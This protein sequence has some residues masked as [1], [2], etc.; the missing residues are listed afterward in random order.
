[1]FRFTIRDVLWLTVVVRFAL[2][3]GHAFAV[4]IPIE[5]RGEWRAVACEALGEKDEDCEKIA[6]L[7]S[8]KGIRVTEG[9]ESWMLVITSLDTSAS[10][11]RIDYRCDDADRQFVAKGIVRCD[12]GSLQ[13]CVVAGDKADGLVRPTEFATRRGDKNRTMCLFSRIEK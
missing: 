1:M 5:L 12:G 9:T 4:E 3:S 11:W 10:P 13:L 6:L 2:A 8:D 7:I